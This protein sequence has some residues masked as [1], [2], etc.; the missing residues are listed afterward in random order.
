[1]RDTA[2][3]IIYVA[4]GEELGRYLALTVLMIGA[5]LLEAL[6]IGI[7]I[8]FLGAVS[9]PEAILANAHM[10][11]LQK[12]SGVALDTHALVLLSGLAMIAVF[13]IK[14]LLIF[15]TSRFQGSVLH[16]QRAQ[17]SRKLFSHYLRLPYS[18]H[19]QKNMAKLIHVTTGVST[20]FATSFMA[21]LLM[22]L[23]E[24][25]VSVAVMTLLF[26]ANPLATLLA[27]A[28]FLTGAGLYMAWGRVR[29]VKVGADM[30]NAAVH[31]NKCVIEGLSSLKE[32]RVLDCEHYF[33]ARYDHLANQY[34][35]SAV[36]M[37]VLGQ[38]PRL[39]IE[40][41][42]VAALVGAVLG[43]LAAG[44]NLKTLI[45]LMALFGM[46]FFRLLPSFN[47]IITSFT[48]ARMNL[49]SL[50]L[51]YQELKEAEHD[52]PALPVA[53]ADAVPLRFESSLR[54]ADVSYSYPGET[55]RALNA[56][57]LEV[58][59]GEVIGLIGKSG[60]GKTTLVDVILGLLPPQEG[61]I[62]V[63]G[64]PVLHK[65]QQW[66]T[67]VG[68]IPQS[69]YLIDDTMRRNIAFGVE[70]DRI[71][72]AA[73]NA[74]L[75]AAQLADFVKTL[76][77]GLD[78][79]VG[80]RGVRL[81]GGQRQRI[82]IARALYRDP[83]ILVLDEATSALDVETETGVSDAIHALGGQKTLII[84]AHRLSTVKDCDRLLL[85]ADGRIV[86]SGRYEELNERNPWFRHINELIA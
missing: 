23:A 17:L 48:T 86:D 4:G 61:D 37:H 9:D 32:T 59:K 3:K 60:A 78:T 74:A 35:Q 50:E 72:E 85:I 18:L 71:D 7:I 83:Q 46:A 45:P 63:D 34:R 33:L 40:S 22:L 26:L 11:A 41:L 36:R 68:Y 52:G 19:L 49:V 77:A 84:I 58:G 44:A 51:L 73:M 69:I 6:G 31:L 38:A 42:F 21:S 55:K 30:D 43:L 56:I 15:L 53:D 28:F 20:N 24:T 62:L 2:R 54:L 67:L 80:D 13:L 14:N 25:L 65:L 29:L 16:G 75:A 57:S 39:V 76:P 1:M 64:A 66:H 5:A 10:V 81:S 79:V 27:T 82:G 8:P 70:D 47:R 12:R